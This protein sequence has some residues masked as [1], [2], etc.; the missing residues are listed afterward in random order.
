MASPLR[1]VLATFHSGCRGRW[2]RCR[3]GEQATDRDWR[4][5]ILVDLHHQKRSD[6]NIMDIRIGLPSRPTL[7]L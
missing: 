2:L 5:I 6:H 3:R 7:D 4:V 1:E